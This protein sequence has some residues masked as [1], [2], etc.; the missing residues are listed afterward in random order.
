MLTNPDTLPDGDWGW[1]RF[2]RSLGS[3]QWPGPPH[4]QRRITT[5]FGAIAVLKSGA[6]NGSGIGGGLG[7]V[8]VSGDASG[9]RNASFAL[10]D[11]DDDYLS[12]DPL[13]HSQVN[14][15]SPPLPVGNLNADGTAAA[16]GGTAYLQVLIDGVT[17][18]STTH[19][20]CLRDYFARAY[21]LPV[22]A[23][24]LAFSQFNTVPFKAITPIGD[25]AY[26]DRGI[27]QLKGSDTERFWCYS[28]AFGF[29]PE[30]NQD[31]DGE[32]FFTMGVN[33]E[34]V[35]AVP[36]G[37]AEIYLETS[38]DFAWDE[39]LPQG[40]VSKPADLRRNYFQRI[41]A[42]VAHELAHAPGRQLGYFD[43]LEG[44]SPADGIMQGGA[45]M[46]FGLLFPSVTI[47]RIRSSSS[48]TGGAP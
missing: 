38:R 5:S 12:D 10:K 9:L 36:A 27:F 22:D 8:T 26:Y 4:G 35:T 21:V 20:Q 23:N 39:A 42:T 15:R 29:Q 30:D 1:R 48:W 16:T 11:D 25:P 24:A 31:G 44:A 19:A 34:S 14:L 41:I 45:P 17:T 32:D 37:H 3:P 43:H 18:S 13:Y 28:V 47:R 6:R 7:I 46:K 2:A 40:F 33:T